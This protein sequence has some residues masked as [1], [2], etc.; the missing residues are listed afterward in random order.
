[1]KVWPVVYPNPLQ[2]LKDL[3]TRIR[4]TPAG[5]SVLCELHE[6]TEECRERGRKIDEAADKFW[7][8][9]YE[10]VI[11]NYEKTHGVGSFER[12]L[13]KKIEEL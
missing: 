12:D 8:A 6:T 2:D 11:F 7:R 4:K 9:Q 10:L 3:R 13:N 1:M 5:C